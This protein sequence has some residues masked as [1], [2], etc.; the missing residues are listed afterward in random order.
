MKRFLVTGLV[1]ILL[2]SFIGGC[3]PTS[4]S[5]EALMWSSRRYDPEWIVVPPRLIGNS[6]GVTEKDIAFDPY[7]VSTANNST[8]SA[9]RK[10]NPFNEVIPAGTNF[11]EIKGYDSKT[12]LALSNGGNYYLY[13][14]A[15]KG[16]LVFPQ[17]AGDAT[18]ESQLAGSSEQAYLE[19]FSFVSAIHT[20]FIVLNILSADMGDPDKLIALIAQYCDQTGSTLL[21]TSFDVIERKGYLTFNGRDRVDWSFADGQFIA[22][23][24]GAISGNNAT[25]MQA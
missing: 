4:Q 25:V 21:V 10:V 23:E 18:L 15:P 20:N 2:I 9:T 6:L 1:A 12:Y 3:V 14:H 24:H 8:G 11:Y 5:A 17:G 7:G 16:K 19:A 22:L 13:A